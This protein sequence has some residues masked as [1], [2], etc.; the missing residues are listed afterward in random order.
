MTTSF[1]QTVANAAVGNVGFTP[2]ANTYAALY[3]TLLDASGSGTEI[4]GNGY[5]RQ[6]ITY[7]SIANGVATSAANV[8]F[9]CSGNAWPTVL[10]MAVLDSSTAGNM[11]FYQP[12]AA[13]NV[14]PGDTVQFDTGNI[15]ITIA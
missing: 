9:T 3:S 12:I 11:L 15:V 7:S 13:R 5:S 14:V 4:A 2:A 1:A 6:E 10:S 8:T